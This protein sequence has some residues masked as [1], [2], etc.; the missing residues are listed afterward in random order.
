V[1]ARTATVPSASRASLPRSVTTGVLSARG[2]PGLEIRDVAHTFGARTALDGV[3]FDVVPGVLTGL[4]GPNGAGKTTLMRVLLGVLT[5]QRGEV[6]YRGGP[7]GQMELRRWGYM[8]Q[9]RGL[10][11]GMR[12]GD[13]VNRPGFG[14][15]SR[16][17]VA[18][19]VVGT[20]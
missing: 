17:C 12:A 4:L 5:P 9:E 16:G 19:G 3:S 15:H 13:S 10:Y 7:V 11:P 18:T 2:S 20:I 1:T 8:P 6:R 14:S